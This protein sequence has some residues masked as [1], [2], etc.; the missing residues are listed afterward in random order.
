MARTVLPS[1]GSGGGRGRSQRRLEQGNDVPAELLRPLETDVRDVAPDAV[2]LGLV[3]RCAGADADAAPT[4][5][6]RLVEGPARVVLGVAV[7]V[8]LVVG[9]PVG[10]HDDEPVAG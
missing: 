8:V 3:G 10:Q 6:A 5:S 7:A 1:S 2:Q 9:E 4:T